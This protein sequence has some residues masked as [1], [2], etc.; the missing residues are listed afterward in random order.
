[1]DD[2]FIEYPVHLVVADDH[3]VNTSSQAQKMPIIYEELA[4]KE[5]IKLYARQLIDNVGSQKATYGKITNL[6]GVQIAMPLEILA[7]NYLEICQIPK[8]CFEAVDSQSIHMGHY[9]RNS[10][11]HNESAGQFYKFKYKI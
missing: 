4:R 7:K 8:A 5:I 10:F 2:N 9:F 1:M 11:N 6:K 3:A